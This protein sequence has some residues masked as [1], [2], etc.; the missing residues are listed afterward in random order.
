MTD[1]LETENTEAT[2]ATEVAAAPVE[3]AAEDR[4][5]TMGWVPKEQFKGDPDKWVDAATF[6]KR[7]EEFLP[8]LKAANKRLERELETV[9]KSMREFAEFHTKTEARAYERALKD[10]EAR[11]EAAAAAGDTQ[12]VKE[13]TKE[14]VGLAKEVSAPKT[15]ANKDVVE[16]WKAENAWYD[17]DPVMRGA[18]FEIANELVEQGITDPA[19]QLA[20]VT[21]RIKAEFP[22][23]FENPKRRE[24]GAVEGNTPVARRGKSRSDLPPEARSTMDRWVKQG[25][26]TEAQYIK[27]YFG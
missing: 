20:E 22:H 23:K 26:I 14:I 12:A 10:L 8:F 13:I 11:Q 3:E 6:I 5:L 7:G 19:K 9:K 27:D 21:R 24:P 17:K 15:N 4:A 25:L 2:E 1:Q 18:A 16:E